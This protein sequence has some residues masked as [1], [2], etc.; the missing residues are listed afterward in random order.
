[1]AE[2]VVRYAEPTGGATSGQCPES[3]PCTIVFA[4]ETAAQPNDEVVVMPG[5]YVL[6]NEVE[7]MD[8]GLDLH[9][10]AGQPRPLI[11]S[12]ALQH[13]LNVTEPATVRDLRVDFSGGAAGVN[14]EASTGQALGERL[15]VHAS[16]GLAACRLGDAAI[17]DSVCRST[18][19]GTDA[20]V[21]TGSG[22]SNDFDATATNVTA[23]ASTPPGSGTYGVFLHAA[24]DPGDGASL[25]LQGK[26]VIAGG[27]DA[28]VRVET[29]GSVSPF[30][31]AFLINSNFE[32]STSFGPGTEG[33]PA[34]EEGDNQTA[35]PVFVN[36][37]SG[38]F[39]QVFGSPT[40]NAG[41]GGL[42]LGT[43]DF[44]GQP[45]VQG[46]APDIGA[47]EF[48]QSSPPGGGGGGDGDPPPPGG[49][50]DNDPP[51]TTIDKGPKKKTKKRKAKFELSSDEPGS[52]FE[53]KLD[54]K[55][56]EPCDSSET[57]KVKR[58]R[59]ALQARAVDQAG[60]ADPTPDSH[61]WKVKKKRKR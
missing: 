21:M 60:N 15:I 46:T 61:A 54:N 25:V 32:I 7:V 29:A 6:S 53:C 51:E 30:A 59:H 26:N 57:F 18:N 19:P 36:A 33:H 10:Q 17:R 5:T 49:G 22:S 35:E 41:T 14:L 39:H 48:P 40:I 24:G 23:H 55:D 45:R 2:A 27:A 37:A 28:D 8:T 50:G 43:T 1:M 13:G 38:N 20:L 47:D 31:A 58:K 44:D 56:F 42:G 16:G 9:G 4:V 3:N 52:S 12:S 11:T 34:P